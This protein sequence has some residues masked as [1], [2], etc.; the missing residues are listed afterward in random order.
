[1]ITLYEYIRQDEILE[2]TWNTK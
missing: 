1:M 2:K